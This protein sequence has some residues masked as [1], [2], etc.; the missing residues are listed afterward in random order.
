MFW[1]YAVSVLSRCYKSKSGVAHV[2]MDPHAAGVPP[3]V[4]VMHM[5]R[6]SIGERVDSCVHEAEQ[7]WAGL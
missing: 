3:S 6:A 1:M 7:A 4:T 5:W 2:A